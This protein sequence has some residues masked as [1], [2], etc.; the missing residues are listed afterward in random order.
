M[1]IYKVKRTHLKNLKD[2]GIKEV[3][4][5]IRI[6]AKDYESVIKKCREEKGLGRGKL[7][8]ESGI[9][10]K[11]IT[12]IEKSGKYPPN[13]NEFFGKLEKV[14]G[15]TLLDKM[16]PVTEDD[17]WY[18]TSYGLLSRLSV[19]ILDKG[20]VEVEH[21]MEMST[22]MKEAAVAIRAN[23]QFLEGITG[24]T[25]KERSKQMKSKVTKD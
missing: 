4:E 19:R 1:G 17:G 18:H 7:A 10:E 6:P 12:K 21:E 16:S 20:M 8:K 9:E 25:A 5:N 24:Y 13:R 14:L 22:D 15:V 11:Y 3:I 2:G 23:N